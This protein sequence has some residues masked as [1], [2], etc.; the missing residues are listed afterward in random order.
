MNNADNVFVSNLLNG[1]QPAD[2]FKAAYQTNSIKGLNSLMKSPEIQAALKDHGVSKRKA[3][4]VIAKQYNAQRPIM[5]PKGAQVQYVDDNAAQIE[6]AKVTYKLLGLLKDNNV[7]IDNRQ[8]TFS[9]DVAQLAKIVEDMKA[10]DHSK[11]IDVDGEV[12]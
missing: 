9:G 8:V 2:A 3:D 1:M 7:V 5:V 12:V 10:L 6:A 4:N 11:A